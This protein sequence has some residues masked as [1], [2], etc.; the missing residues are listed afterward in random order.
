MITSIRDYKCLNV[1]SNIHLQIKGMLSIEKIFSLHSG[2]VIWK[3]NRKFKL[4]L[5]VI[6]L[7]FLIF[8]EKKFPTN[9][10]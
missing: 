8:D 3:K 10:C 6:V 5:D 9:V 4:L 7:K 1:V 2:V